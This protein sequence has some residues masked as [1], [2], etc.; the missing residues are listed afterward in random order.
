MLLKRPVAWSE[1][2]K[3]REFGEIADW[4]IYFFF[5]GGWIGLG[6]A[7]L[8]A[9]F[10][11]FALHHWWGGVAQGFRIFVLSSLFGAASTISGW[12]LGLLF[13]IP[14][15]LARANVT[16]AAGATAAA[17]AVARSSRVN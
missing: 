4:F 13:G 6:V 15:S 11:E 2:M 7:G 12:L 8:A 9:A 10:E 17:A 14:R 1:A 3:R 5:Y 16:A